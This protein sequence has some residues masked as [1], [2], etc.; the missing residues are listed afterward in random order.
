M[1][2][3]SNAKVQV[4]QGWLQGYTEG[5]LKIFKGIPYAA[6]PVGELRFRHPQD[7]GRWRG[8]RRATQYLSLIH[9]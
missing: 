7:P 4:K 3:F 1:D 8:V 2:N 6:P 9:I 5:D